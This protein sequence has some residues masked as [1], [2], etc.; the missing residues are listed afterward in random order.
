M[1]QWVAIVVLIALA[2][3][4]GSALSRLRKIQRDVEF[5][6]SHLDLPKKH[7]D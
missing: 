6:K 5:I 3:V 4:M 7:E 1:E 2:F